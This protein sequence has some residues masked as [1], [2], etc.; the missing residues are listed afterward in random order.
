MLCLQIVLFGIIKTNIAIQDSIRATPSSPDQLTAWNDT[1]RLMLQTVKVLMTTYAEKLDSSQRGNAWTTLLDY[2]QQYFTC[3]SH[4]LGSSVFDTITGILSQTENADSLGMSPLLK[5]ADIWNAYWDSREKWSAETEGNQNAFVSYVDSFKALYRLADRSLDPQMSTMLGN[6]EACIA[7]SDV[8]AYSTDVNNMTTLQ[9]KVMACLSMIKTESPGLPSTLIQLLSRFSVLPYTVS[10]E[11][12][13]RPRP[14]FVA[15]AKASMALLQDI[16]VRHIGQ[17]EIYTSQAFLSALRSLEKAIQEKYIWQREGKSPALWQKATTTVITI[18]GPGLSQISAHTDGGESLQEYWGT[19]VDIAKYITRAQ[20]PS[21]DDPPSS[22][23]N[24]E[25]FDIQSFKKLRS[26]ITD[27]LG[28]NL[29]PDNLRRSYTRNLFTMSLVH[30]PLPVELPD[31]VNA[32]LDE[33]YK[34]RYGQTARLEAS[35]RTEMSYTCLAELFRLVTVHNSS[36]SNIKLA[37]AAAPYLILRAALPL[38]TYIADHPLRGRMPA[39]ESERREL[40]MVLKM[41]CDMRIEPLAIPNPPGVSSK[42]RKHL[43]RLYP[44]LNKVSKVARYDNQVLESIQKLMEI[45]G[46]EFDMDDD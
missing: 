18:L 3:G 10:M 32:P 43:H 44:L 26:L 41:L 1:T 21:A 35:L 34:I 33:L 16:T 2:L 36:A 40:L 15:L 38:K 30:T 42:H 14:T 22:L 12:S 4:A 46:E 25:T 37:Q 17:K 24:D 6:L 27:P 45:V 13:D 7:N 11:N 9:S 5:T 29:I 20:I 23:E 8:V 28:S 39:P 31:L 19:L